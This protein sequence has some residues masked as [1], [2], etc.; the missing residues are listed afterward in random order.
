MRKVL[1]LMVAALA[2]TGW[3]F[4]QDQDNAAKPQDQDNAAK[5]DMKK[6]GKDT[7]DAAKATGRGVKH[8]AKWTKDKVTG[9]DKDKDRVP[10]SDRD[11]NTDRD[12]AADRDRDR[13]SVV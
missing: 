4:A 5:Q 13:K 6:A 3:S 9:D 7:K 10:Q 2:L 11:A 12:R 1:M 8:G